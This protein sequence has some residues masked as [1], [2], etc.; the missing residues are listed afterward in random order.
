MF[1]QTKLSKLRIPDE[2]K[3][4]YKKKEH[5]NDN[6]YRLHFQLAQEWGK[7]S[8]LIENSISE[9]LKKPIQDIHN[10]LNKK[11]Q[12]LRYAH[13]KNCVVFDCI[14]YKSCNCH[15]HCFLHV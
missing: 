2:I 5:T 13:P 11:L 1:T 12:Y 8:H 14:T 15:S 7:S 10:Q 6:L 4:L 3:F 9:S